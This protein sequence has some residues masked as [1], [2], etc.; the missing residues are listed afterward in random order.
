[1][2]RTKLSGVTPEQSR[3]ESS[4]E[5]EVGSVVT[6]RLDGIKKQR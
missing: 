3:T 1:M 5:A 2:G 4:V 6:K